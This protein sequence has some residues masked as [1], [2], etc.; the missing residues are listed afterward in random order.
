MKVTIFD[1]GAGNLHS[2]SK[3]V[4]ATGALPVIE[5][6]PERAVET[7]VLILPGVG[8]FGPAAARLAP[9]RERI[10][11]AALGGLPVLGICLGLQLLFDTSEEGD[12]QGL[13]LIAGRVSRID[14][15][16]LPQIGWNA[17]EDVTDPLV[18]RAALT[19]GYY[20]NSFV[21]RPA[22]SAVVTAWSTYDR[23]RFPAVVRIGRTLGVQ[24]HP[25][26]SSAPGVA[27]IA[28]FLEA[29]RP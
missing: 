10:R 18:D 20:A 13:G 25:E 26:K 22:D 5:A 29:S 28:G 14:A 6:S 4:A 8:A 23:D 21:G 1:Y 15:V 7:D 12:G 9:G 24:F 16:R 11:E 17:I 19:Q 2:L 27:M 3:A